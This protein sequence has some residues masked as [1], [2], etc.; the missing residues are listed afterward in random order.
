[1]MSI[2]P[3]EVGSFFLSLVVPIT[4][5]VAAAGFTAYFALNRFYREKWWEKKHSSYNQLLDK[6]FEIKAIYQYAAD[7]GER[8]YKASMRGESGPDGEVDWAR[9]HEI[10]S[11]LHRF[12]V[13][14]PISLSTSTR[15]LLSDFFK[16][17]AASDYSVHEEGNPS[18]IAYGEMAKAAQ[19]LIEAIVRDAEKELKF[20]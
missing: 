1:M 19:K 4:T 20:T 7:L 14:A 16:E 11:Q 9:Y 15:D 13:L 17:D 2:T 18:F 6:I 5:G 3:V 10:N 12:Y 8:E